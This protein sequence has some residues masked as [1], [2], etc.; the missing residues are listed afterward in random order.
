MNQKLAPETAT[1][2]ALHPQLER[3]TAP[4]G[5]LPLCRV[6]LIAMASFVLRVVNAA[7][8]SRA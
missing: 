1:G 6:L 8:F 7:W 5:D 4:V 3:D 2:W